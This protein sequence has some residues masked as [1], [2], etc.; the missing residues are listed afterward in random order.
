MFKAYFSA[1]NKSNHEMI[2]IYNFKMKFSKISEARTKCNLEFITVLT[3]VMYS[4]QTG[5]I[6]PISDVERDYL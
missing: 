6:G 1:K 4:V 3:N 2:D 5:I